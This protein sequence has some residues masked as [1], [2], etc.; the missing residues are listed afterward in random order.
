MQKLQNVGERRMAVDLPG[1]DLVKGT[2][3]PLVPLPAG[4][5]TVIRLLRKAAGAEGDE[6]VAAVNVSVGGVLFEKEPKKAP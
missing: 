2:G 1:A 5:Q 3:R 6:L 4:A